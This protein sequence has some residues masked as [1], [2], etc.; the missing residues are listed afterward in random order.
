MVKG[1]IIKKAGNSNKIEN[2][3]IIFSDFLVNNGE[4]AAQKYG[5]ILNKVIELTKNKI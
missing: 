5:Y 3:E 4:N 1:D 2:K